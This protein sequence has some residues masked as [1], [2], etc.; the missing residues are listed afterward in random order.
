MME[1]YQAEQRRE[2]A[3]DIDTTTFGVPAAEVTTRVDVS[4]HTP[5]QRGRR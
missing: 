2:D 1:R 3:P 4:A 5:K